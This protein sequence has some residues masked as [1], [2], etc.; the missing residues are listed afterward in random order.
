VV[1]YKEALLVPLLFILYINDVIAV[2]ATEGCVC[3]L[4]A[5]D[6][7][8]YTVLHTNAN[9]FD[10]QRRLDELQAWS[11][12]WQLKISLKKCVSLLINRLGSET[13]SALTLGKNELARV[14]GS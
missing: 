10:L 4:Y 3:Q 13:N 1:L 7:K 2:L 5:D 12:A 9:V 11:D 6:L 14:D 8:L